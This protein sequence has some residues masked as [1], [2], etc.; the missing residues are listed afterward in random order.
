MEAWRREGLE[1]D[2]A[3]N[4]SADGH[5]GSGSRRRG[6]ARPSHAHGVPPTSL[7]LEITESAVMRDPVLA[8]RNMQ[9][10]Q[11]SGVRFAI[12]DFGTGYSSLSHL[13]RLP[14]RRAEDRPVA[15]RACA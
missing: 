14:L 1:I 12:D 11:V 2:V 13:S 10:L 7:L 3:V 9:L 8:A 5:S 6:A 4:L 15:A